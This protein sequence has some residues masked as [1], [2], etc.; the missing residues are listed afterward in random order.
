MRASSS[1]IDL[2]RLCLDQ[3]T[4]ILK[5]QQT[6]VKLLEELLMFRA[7]SDEENRMAE[8]AEKGENHE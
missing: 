5:Q 8:M 4:T 3:Q 7:L 6:I 1:V 2:E